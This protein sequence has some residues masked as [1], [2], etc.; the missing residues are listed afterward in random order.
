MA[1]PL[2]VVR[3]KKNGG[4]KKKI[5]NRAIEMRTQIACTRRLF[6]HDVL[7]LPECALRR[8][9]YP[10]FP[11][12]TAAAEMLDLVTEKRAIVLQRNLGREATIL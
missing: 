11:D 7:I 9:Y 5:R 1:S 6:K 10:L 3:C 2:L 8:C 4:K 12:D